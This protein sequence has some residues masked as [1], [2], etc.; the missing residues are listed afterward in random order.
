MRQA[1]ITGIGIVSSIGNNA[2][3]VRNSLKEGR[4]GISFCQEYADMGFRSHIHGAP[5]ID[6]DASI[7]RRVRR[8]MGDGA[9]YNYLAMEQ[10]IAD[11]GL[12]ESEVSDERTGLIM[13]SGGPSVRNLID[14]ADTARQRGPKKVGPFMVPR[15]IW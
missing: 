10:A 3:E 14:A 15:A 13:G 1:A 9:A 2:D 12:T 4:S 7:D 5:K 8:F 11:S 6:L